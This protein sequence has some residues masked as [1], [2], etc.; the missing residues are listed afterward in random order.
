MKK[1]FLSLV[2]FSILFVIGCQ[3]NT[4]T[5]PL[6]TE[7]SET[8]SIT[9]ETADKNLP[10]DYQDVPEIIRFEKELPSPYPN[11]AP[12]SFVVAG[13]IEVDHKVWQLDPIPPNPQYHVKVGLS[14]DA[15]MNSTAGQERNRWFIKGNTENTIFF[16]GDEVFTLTKYYTVAGR[17]D[18]MQLVCEFEVTVRGV[19]L[20]DMELRLPK[21]RIDE[22]IN[23]F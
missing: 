3:E 14:M 19:A 5:D 12:K 13:T 22:I 2:V 20:L 7:S 4:I 17:S 1:L 10:Q 8:Q 18:R 6:S 21:Y 9:T 11:L 15:E 23:N 16:T